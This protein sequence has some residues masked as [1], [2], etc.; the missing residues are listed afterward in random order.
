VDLHLEHI[1]SL[2][3]LTIRCLTG[4][5]LEVLGRQA[6]RSLDAEVLA[7]GTINELGADLLE[8]LAVAR[9]EGNSDLVDFLL[10]K[11]C[12]KTVKRICRLRNKH[13]G[14]SPKSFS[15]FWYDIFT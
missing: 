10:A 6:N 11:F 15:P 1:P 14:P 4:G 3:T 2:G 7:L 12:Q 13:T 8:G 9:S 5:N